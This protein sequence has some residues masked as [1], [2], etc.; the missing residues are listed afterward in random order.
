MFAVVGWIVHLS[1]SIALPLYSLR[2]AVPMG[3][4]TRA[5]LDTSASFFSFL[6]AIQMFLLRARPHDVEAWKILQSAIL[7]L[8]FGRI[9]GLVR[10]LETETNIVSKTG[11]SEYPILSFFP[12]NHSYFLSASLPVHPTQL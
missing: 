12:T 2:P 9:L 1:P 7:V 11:H 4:E 6:A 3:T 8:D 5:L 10:A